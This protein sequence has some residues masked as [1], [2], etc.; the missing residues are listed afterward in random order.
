MGVIQKQAQ[1]ACVEEIEIDSPLP[2]V[3]AVEAVFARSIQ[4]VH[5]YR[6]LNRC[7]VSCSGMSYT[8]VT[9]AP[10]GVRAFMPRPSLPVWQSAWPAGM[11]GTPERD[12]AQNECVK[13]VRA[14]YHY[15]H[16]NSSCVSVFMRDEPW[17]IGVWNRGVLQW[18]AHLRH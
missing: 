15:C 18:H 7:R 6:V 1:E 16:V 11:E 14:E 2:W 4:P 8:E 10:R 13:W 5:V 9:V 17:W 3:Q 12:E